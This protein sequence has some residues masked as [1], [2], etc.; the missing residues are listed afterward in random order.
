MLQRVVRE[1][2]EPSDRPADI[3]AQAGDRVAA[4]LRAAERADLLVLGQQSPNKLKDLLLL[5]TAHRVVERSRSPVLVVKKTVNAAYQ[6][7]LVPFDFTPVSESASMFAGS[8]APDVELHFLHAL[9]SRKDVV[10][11][12]ARVPDNVIRETLQSEDQ[13]LVARMRSQLAGLGLARPDMQFR[14]SGAWPSRQFSKRNGLTRS[15]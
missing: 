12:H 5:Y 14:S 15:T 4:L 3:D 6:H 11:R 2:G 1:V 8:L 9:Y 13:A 7:V 10:L